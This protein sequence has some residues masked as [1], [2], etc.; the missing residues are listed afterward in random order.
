MERVLDAPANKDLTLAGASAILFA[1]DAG[2]RGLRVSNTKDA[3]AFVHQVNKKRALQERVGALK[4][5]DW[6]SFFALAAELGY[7]V[8]LETFYYGCLSDKVVHF[9]PELIK[10]AGQLYSYKM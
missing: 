2:V 6:A 8:D 1:A 10:F 5:R 3:V 4:P 9:C 7:D